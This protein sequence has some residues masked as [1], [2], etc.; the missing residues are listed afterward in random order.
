MAALGGLSPQKRG[1]GQET[2]LKVKLPF[3]GTSQVPGAARN[4]VRIVLLICKKTQIKTVAQ[5]WASSPRVAWREAGLGFLPRDAQFCPEAPPL[6][7][8]LAP[9]VHAEA[10]MRSLSLCLSLSLSDWTPMAKTQKGT[11]WPTPLSG[12]VLASV[13]S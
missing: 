2:V 10:R 8:S 12:S 5:H 6:S 3:S 4:T 13:H 11:V 9:G 7:A 1:R